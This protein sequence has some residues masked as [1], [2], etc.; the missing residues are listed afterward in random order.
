M[1]V[2]R[3]FNCITVYEVRVMEKRIKFSFLLV[4]FLLIFTN[5]VFAQSTDYMKD[6]DSVTENPQSAY[7]MYIGMLSQDFQANFENL[8]GWKYY[9][10]S[11][12]DKNGKVSPY[13]VVK[14]IKQG[15]DVAET[16]NVISSS[17]LNQ[18][19]MLE[20]F[21]NCFYTNSYVIAKQ[22]YDRAVNNFQYN[23]GEPTPNKLRA[24]AG[25]AW[26]IPSQN[27]RVFVSLEEI[28]SSERSKYFN[29]QY[30]IRVGR[31]KDKLY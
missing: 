14:N 21:N 6:V 26:Q 9:G 7:T 23:L 29:A 19:N 3:K 18:A 10:N 16:I 15:D 13:S 30:R 1:K 2:C 24:L 20:T 17:N 25:V 5:S 12:F 8:N 4:G 27:L 31:T 28:S 22:I 11:F